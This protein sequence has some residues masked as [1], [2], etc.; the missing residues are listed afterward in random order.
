MTDTY[1]DRVAETERVK[2]RKRARVERGAGDVAEEPGN[3]NDE[4]VR[5]VR[6]ADASGGYIVENQHEEDRMRDIQV[7]K[8]GSEAAS[9]E[10]SEKLRKK[11]LFELEAPK[12]EHLP[13]HVLL[14]NI[15]RVVRH[16]VGRG[17]Y[18]CRSQGMLM[19]TYKFMRW[20][21]ST[22][23]MDERVTSE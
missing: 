10:Q 5:H 18:L 9:E 6:H 2:E 3:R 23:W 16:K 11:A 13:I 20:I 7:C 22:R 19:T 14:W 15:L 8:R 4:Q 17:P 21:Q 1:K 12:H